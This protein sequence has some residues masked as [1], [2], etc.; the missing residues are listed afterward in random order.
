M[1]KKIYLYTALPMLQWWDW[2]MRSDEIYVW[3]HTLDNITSE[4][5]N[6]PDFQESLFFIFF[7]KEIRYFHNLHRENPFCCFSM[8]R[9]NPIS[10]AS[11]M[12][13]S[14]TVNFLTRILVLQR[15]CNRHFTCHLSIQSNHSPT[16]SHQCQLGPTS[17]NPEDCGIMLLLS[18]YT[19]TW[20]KNPE[21]YS[22][23]L[24]IIDRFIIWVWG[25]GNSFYLWISIPLPRHFL[26]FL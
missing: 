17:F 14:V 4:G 21:D 12:N 13:K 19:T 20:Y 1:L 22:M 2:I 16:W 3:W 24:V 9:Y 10:I 25:R 15:V 11:C 6:C 7:R 18:T 23:K 5:W 8:F 26:V